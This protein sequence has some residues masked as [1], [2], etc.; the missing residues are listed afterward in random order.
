M[1]ETTAPRSEP[2]LGADTAASDEDSGRLVNAS[3]GRLISILVALVLFSEVVPLQYTMV[4]VI[5]PK[6]GAAFPQSGN[7]TSWALTILGVVG[8]A[9]IALVGKASDLVGK[10]LVLL[11]ISVFFLAG[12]VVCALTDS[13][14]VFLLGRGLQALSLGMPAVTYGVVR[15]LMPRRWIP[16]C[17]GFI[18]TGFGVAAIIAPLVGGGLTDHYSWRAVFWFLVIYMIVTIPLV[19]A[20]VPDSPFRVRQR[21]DW[22]GAILFGGGIA[23]VLVYISEGA[24]WGWTSSGCLPY[25]I[26][27]LVALLAWA[28]WENRISY[29]MMELSLLRAPKVSMIMG[30]AVFATIGVT[31]PNFIIPYMN[32]T[33]KAS[34][35]KGEILAQTAAAQHYPVSIVAQFVHFQGDI[36]YAAGFSVFQL[37]WHITIFTAGSA[38]IFGP[39]GGILARR[40]GARLP[41]VIGSAAL[42]A[43]FLLWWQFHDTWRDD[44]AIGLLWGLGF[45]F[46]YGSSPNLLIDAVPAK[47]QGISAGMLA[48]FGAVGSALATALITPILASH[49]FQ[50]VATPPGGKPIVHDIP[51]VYT[52]A[53]YGEAYLLI[54]VIGAVITVALAVMLRTG[55]EP[56]LGGASSQAPAPASAVV[57]A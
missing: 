22:L 42:L 35:L 39:I 36:G 52:D 8:A 21:F 4:G 46:Y 24:G 11:A 15:D 56:A 28:A 50:L 1:S 16:I 43:T 38:M 5:I 53:G 57:E 45:G 13:W 33:P 54:G 47:R 25:L 34:V 55:R 51:Q 18:G 26:G 23:G 9:T 10:K 20:I 7:S 2:P 3:T 27:G 49:P 12:T 32:E 31:L 41:L 29:P 48:V 30:I 19:V 17:I 14:A 44:A 37:A 6:I 40:F